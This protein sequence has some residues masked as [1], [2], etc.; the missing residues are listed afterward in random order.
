MKLKVANVL[1]EGNP[2]KVKDTER[3][4][5]LDNTKVYDTDLLTHEQRSNFMRLLAVG[6][7]VEVSSTSPA[8]SVSPASKVGE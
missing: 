8:P 3:N 7:L 1:V 6:D 2:L 5:Y 4:E